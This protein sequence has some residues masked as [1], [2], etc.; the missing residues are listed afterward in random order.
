MLINRK[1]HKKLEF[2]V[3]NKVKIK[4]FYT[5]VTHRSARAT[6]QLNFEETIK[7]DNIEIMYILPGEE[8]NTKK[9]E[10]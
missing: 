1:R 4:V 8:N 9:G 7:S 5:N 3:L 6:L 2:N 10:D